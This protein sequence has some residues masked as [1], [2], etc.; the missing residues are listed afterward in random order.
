MRKK[1]GKKGEE[2]KDVDQGSVQRRVKERGTGRQNVVG[3]LDWARSRKG[4]ART[5]VYNSYF[6]LTLNWI[7]VTYKQLKY[8]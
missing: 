1:T 5:V 2:K 6:R 3:Q 8:G 4:W 7:Q